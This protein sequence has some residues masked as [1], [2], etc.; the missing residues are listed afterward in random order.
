MFRRLIAKLIVIPLRREPALLRLRHHLLPVDLSIL[1]QHHLVCLNLLRNLLLMH[2][3]ARDKSE[4]S[5]A[6][7]FSLFL[8][9]L[10]PFNLRLEIGLA[11]LDLLSLLALFPSVHDCL[12]VIL[13]PIILL[14]GGYHFVVVQL[15]LALCL[16][17]FRFLQGDLF[18]PLQQRC[19]ILFLL[20]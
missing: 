13:L 20:S 3:P 19:Q 6:L 11:G 7:R 10:A 4:F 5:R 17:H 16:A 12:L 8:T 1:T 14:L 2:S 9:G 15:G 18:R